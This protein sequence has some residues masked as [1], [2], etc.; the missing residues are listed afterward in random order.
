MHAT[1]NLTPS[2]ANPQNRELYLFYYDIL[3]DDTLSRKMSY[4]YT[5][6]NKLYDA[7]IKVHLLAS[8]QGL[9]LYTNKS[10]VLGYIYFSSQWDSSMVVLTPPAERI[11]SLLLKFSTTWF[12]RI[13]ALDFSID[14]STRP[15]VRSLPVGYAHG[16]T[17]HD[18]LR[19][20]FLR[21]HWWTKSQK[22]RGKNTRTHTGTRTSS[23]TQGG[24]STSIDRVLYS[25]R[26]PV[27]EISKQFAFIRP[28]RI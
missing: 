7:K 27:Q 11:C 24:F 22:K 14:W 3:R 13:V 10:R 12:F 9:C 5:D 6:T 4:Y 23:R 19:H 26:V 21:Q 8:R 16:R 20:W 17:T 28:S 2:R 15:L 1:Y 18:F 25:L